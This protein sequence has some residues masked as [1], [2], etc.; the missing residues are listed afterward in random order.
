[1]SNLSIFDIP[2]EA[3][4]N[5][6]S[7][8]YKGTDIDIHQACKEMRQ[9][10]PIYEG[11]FIAQFGVPT[12]A[13]LAQGTKPT[14][15]LF[16]YDDVKQILLDGETYTSGFILKGLGAAF[17]GGLFILGL[18]G[19]QHRKVRQLLQPA[20]MPATVNKWRDKIDGVIRNDFLEPMVEQKKANL[21]DFGL[22]FP[23]RIMYSLMGFP[24]KDTDQYKQFASWSLLMA[25]ANQIDPDKIE[26]ARRLGMLAAEGLYDAIEE[27]VIKRREEGVEEGDDLIAHL[28]RA[29]YEGQHLTDHEVVTFVRSLLPAAGETT[30]RTFS[31]VLTMLFTIPGM[32]DRVRNDR[33]LVAKLID[34]TVRYEPIATFKV[35][36]TSRNVELHGVEIPKGSFVQAM[37]VSANRD[38]K[39]FENP[40]EFNLERKARPTFS[41][42]FG[43]H[44]CIGQFVAKIELNC[45]INS[46]LDLFP[47]IRLDP[48]K[49]APEIQGAQLRGTSEVHLIWD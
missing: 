41:F 44:T 12:N 23:I 7:Q 48:E 42:G 2:L 36:E 16:D 3:S 13:G 14:F 38:E 45:A 22:Y 49:P 24:V 18:D 29:D 34:E 9:K 5:V 15:T 39:V 26:D 27:V 47:N 6:V 40:E 8:T 31:C 20:F 30:T 43:P 35:R 25:G 28:L 21:I 32:L 46:V 1:M 33:S 4:Y 11:D 19:E 37:V 10:S 17:E